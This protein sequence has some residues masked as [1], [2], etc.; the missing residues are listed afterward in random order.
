MGP[1]IQSGPR[2]RYSNG[3][4]KQVVSKQIMSDKLSWRARSFFFLRHSVGVRARAPGASIRHV[5]SAKDG[6]CFVT[7]ETSR[8]LG[9]AFLRCWN[10]RCDVYAAKMEPAH[11]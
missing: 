4:R 3:P 6:F 8:F 2:L 5:M 9:A 10:N 11:L 7:V 1:R